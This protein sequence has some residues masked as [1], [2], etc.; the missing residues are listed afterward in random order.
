MEPVCMSWCNIQALNVVSHSIYIIQD[1]ANDV[2]SHFITSWLVRDLKLLYLWNITWN[3]YVPLGILTC[4]G[5]VEF[6]C[7]FL[8]CL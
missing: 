6:C 4:L 2:S 7:L 1:E 8:N 3:D 5:F